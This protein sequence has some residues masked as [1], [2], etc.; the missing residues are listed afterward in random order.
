MDEM[1]EF[2]RVT[3]EK[4]GRVI[5]NHVPVTLLS[6]ELDGETTRVTSA[7]RISESVLFH[8]STKAFNVHEV[9]APKCCKEENGLAYSHA[10]QTRHQQWRTAR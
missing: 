3:Q 8:G 10:S 7:Y 5:C 9:L 2:G 6:A 1:R 4:D